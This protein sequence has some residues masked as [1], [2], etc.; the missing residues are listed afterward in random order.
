MNVP[1][2]NPAVVARVNAV[3]ARHRSA[4]GQVRHFTHPRC[5]QLIGDRARVSWKPGTRDIDKSNK[6]LTHA[7]DA[8]DY[9]L[10]ALYPVTP[11]GEAVVGTPDNYRPDPDSM[12]GVQF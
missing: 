5:K 12:M 6:K 3:N 11:A 2:R 1:S 7:S 8:S 10:V 4:D 9:R